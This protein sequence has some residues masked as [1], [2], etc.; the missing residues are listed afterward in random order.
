MIGLL[1]AILIILS[2]FYAVSILY[3]MR[4]LLRKYPAS[5]SKMHRFTAIIPAHNEEMSI[6]GCLESIAAQEYP[7]DMF[8]VI[9]VDDRS[10]DDTFKIAFEF[11][12]S[13]TNFRC[14]RIEEAAGVV[15]KKTAISRAVSEST[16]EIIIATDADCI[17]S[18]H[19]LTVINSYYTD[20]VGLVA[21]HVTYNKPS[22]L[23]EGID[24]IDYFSH[25][26]MG[27]A[28]VGV[29]SAYTCTSAN[30]SYRKNV[31]LKA[32]N[33]FKSLG[34]RPADDNFMLNFV[35]R[36]TDYDVAVADNER[37]FARTS[38]AR[39][40]RHF[41]DQRF[42]WAAYGQGGGKGMMS[43]FMPMLSYYVILWLSV[44]AAFFDY[45]M[46]GLLGA[47]LLLKLIADFI[48][49]LKSTS[50]FGN[51]G[52]LK[53][54]PP[55]WLINLIMVPVVVFKGNLAGFEWKKRRFDKT[56]EV[57]V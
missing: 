5:N 55:A 48:F 39:N 27:A 47:S 36:K 40:L 23:M 8:E 37:S 29:G 28:F 35:H 13:R 10:T 31:F 9:V 51:R 15:P 46:I 7:E 11:C 26:A 42:R 3:L 19:W 38:G 56:A 49:M 50:V 32:E 24:A 41:L 20:K 34:V 44:A 52:L 21:G 12:R 16:G 53:Y 17:V 6:A 33:E 18:P 30:L 45:T 25:R 43:F 2:V 22:N 1:K 54:F 57:R 4:G 14:L